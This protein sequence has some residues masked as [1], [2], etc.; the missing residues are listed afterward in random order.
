ME[1]D[2]SS[3]TRKDIVDVNSNTLHPSILSMCINGQWN[4]TIE[5]YKCTR[6]FHLSSESCMKEKNAS[7]Y[8]IYI[9]YIQLSLITR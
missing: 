3:G 5:N 6:K 7:N 9:C 2:R 1:K 4:A 8:Y